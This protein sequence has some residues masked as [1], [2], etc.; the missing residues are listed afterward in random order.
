MSKVT[1]ETDEDKEGVVIDN[2]TGDIVEDILEEKVEDIVEE[3]ATDIVDASVAIA[4]IEADKDIK[5]AEIAADTQLQL[6]ENELEREQE[7]WT[8]LQELRE[9][10]SALTVRLEAMETAAL[11]TPQPLTE[12]LTETVQEISE[13]E[14][15]NNLTPQ[16]MSPPISETETEATLESEDGKQ[17]QL[18]I[19]TTTKRRLI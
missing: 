5:L 15:L 3:T 6:Q 2:D 14:A 9:T 19:K 16:F 13:A 4:A 10:V 1:I 8:E 18:A 7:Q 12:A 11:S 17:A